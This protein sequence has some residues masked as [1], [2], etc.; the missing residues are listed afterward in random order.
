MKFFGVLS[1]GGVALLAMASANAAGSGL[2]PRF[3]A[4]TVDAVAALARQHLPEAVLEDGSPV[5]PETPEEL[6][7][8]LL[9]PQIVK[10]A[11]DL[12]VA[13]SYGE[14]CKLDWKSHYL[15]Y[16]KRERDELRRTSKQMAYLGLI[17]GIM[18]GVSQKMAPGKTTCSPAEVA[19]I[20][21]K[22]SAP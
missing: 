3:D 16:M 6:S 19:A 14:Y 12:G 15:A 9:P 7:R 21:D 13:S 11:M 20:E 8:P 2:F 5:P 10:Q 22:L 1:I 4:K 18:M 17:H